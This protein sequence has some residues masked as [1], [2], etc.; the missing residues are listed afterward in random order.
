MGDVF[1]FR[2][3]K[4]DHTLGYRLVPEDDAA[5][6]IPPMSPEDRARI[7]LERAPQAV[8]R[9]MAD[10][11]TA[12]LLGSLRTIVAMQSPSSRPNNIYR[13]FFGLMRTA[14][15][16][17]LAKPVILRLA[18]VFPGHVAAYHANGVAVITSNGQVMALT[19]TQALE[20]LGSS[21]LTSET[22]GEEWI[23]TRFGYVTSRVMYDELQRRS[24]GAFDAMSRRPV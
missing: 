15:P 4:C 23:R 12:G 3:P 18:S 19:S 5:L 16:L 21:R 10:L 14:Q 24:L 7:W 22:V 17:R 1:R 8:Q 11:E 20:Q 9:L 6:Y 2:C 13:Y